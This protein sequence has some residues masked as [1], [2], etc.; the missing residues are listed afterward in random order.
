V[1]VALVLRWSLSPI[2][3]GGW[4]AWSPR[5]RRFAALLPALLAGRSLLSQIAVYPAQWPAARERPAS[6][7]AVDRGPSVVRSAASIRTVCPVAGRV[8]SA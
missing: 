5:R 2:E 6:V 1:V 7:P 3:S 8:A 4:S